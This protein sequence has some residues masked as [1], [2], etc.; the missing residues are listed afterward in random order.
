MT[1]QVQKLREMTGAGVMECKRALEE[2]GGDMDKAVSIIH[3]RGLIKAEKKAK[4]QPARGYWKPISTTKEWGFCWSFA[5]RRILW[6]GQKISGIWLIL[7]PCRSRQW[8]R[9][10]LMN[11]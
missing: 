10:A 3:E 7:W 5:A 2:S 11:F 1:G 8:D 6:L 4:G 9:K